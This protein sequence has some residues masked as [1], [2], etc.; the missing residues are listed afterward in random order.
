MRFTLVPNSRGARFSVIVK[1]PRPVLL[2]VACGRSRSTTKVPAFP[3][4]VQVASVS[5]EGRQSTA[6]VVQMS[7]EGWV[8][9]LLALIPIA[10][11]RGPNSGIFC[12]RICSFT[13]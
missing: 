12:F 9:A 10:K 1:T 2:E 11:T 6:F 8:S 13:L 5:H 4:A 7:K 3:E